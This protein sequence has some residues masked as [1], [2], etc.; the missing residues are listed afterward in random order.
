MDQQPHTTFQQ[1]WC[2]QE[3]R[4]NQSILAIP[5]T[6][7]P[8]CLQSACAHWATRTQIRAAAQQAQAQGLHHATQLLNQLLHRATPHG[9]MGRYLAAGRAPHAALPDTLWPDPAACTLGEVAARLRAAIRQAWWPG[10]PDQIQQP[11]QLGGA[12]DYLH[13]DCARPS[14]SMEAQ[15]R[16]LMAEGAATGPDTAAAALRTALVNTALTTKC[17]PINAPGTEG[18]LPPG[19]TTHTRAHPA[20]SQRRRPAAQH[21]KPT[22]LRVQLF[23]RVRLGAHRWIAWLRH[24]PPPAGDWSMDATH[25]CNNKNC[26]NPYHILWVSDAGSSRDQ[27]YASARSTRRTAGGG[28][29]GATCWAGTASGLGCSAHRRFARA[30]TRTHTTTYGT[31][32]R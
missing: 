13:A 24:G 22:Y 1:W 4:A 14:L 28:V 10:I 21:D 5:N 31:E 29:G 2:D 16:A 20:R 26:L 6:H 3:Q 7:M 19:C 11:M 17:M 9:H 15:Q 27:R 23:S 32:R 18:M 25:L 30:L 12:I 8:P